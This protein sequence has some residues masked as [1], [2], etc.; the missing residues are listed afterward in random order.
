MHHLHTDT[1]ADSQAAHTHS[2][3]VCLV[4]AAQV[5]SQCTSVQSTTHS[6]SCTHVHSMHGHL[7]TA[8]PPQAYTGTTGMLQ[9]CPVH[10][11]TVCFSP[12]CC[13]QLSLQCQSQTRARFLL[14]CQK[15]AVWSGW[16]CWLAD[17]PD[18]HADVQACGYV[19]RGSTH[20]CS[21]ALGFKNA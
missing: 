14:W 19:T 12:L 16:L 8:A 4:N 11:S 17:C 1:Q 18:G 21:R 5:R 13:S 7:V 2:R 15:F 3:R 20:L 6:H 9:P 10:C